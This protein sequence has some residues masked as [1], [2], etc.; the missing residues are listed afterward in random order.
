[1]SDRL[2]VSTVLL[3]KNCA[4]TLSAYF[5]SMQEV[6]DIILMDGGST[7]GTI[8][9][10]KAQSNC[11][12]FPQNP[13]FIDEQ[14]YI[15]DFSSIRN[16][17]YDLARHKW[18]LCIDADETA[19]AKLLAEVR[20]IV[21]TGKSGV[22]FAHRIF[23]YKGKPV[24]YLKKSASDQIRLF[25]LDSVRGCVKPVHEK[26]DVLPGSYRGMLDIELHIP[27]P[28]VEG[29]RRR[30]DRYLNIEVR[31]NKDIQLLRWFRWIFL[32]NL[33]A[34]PR[35]ILVS[36]LTRLIPKRGPRYP[37]ALEWEHWRYSWLLIWRTCPLFRRS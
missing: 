33:I 21:E 28:P 32:R 30:Y 18:I 3:T 24:V 22:Y 25:H 7:D 14:G 9:L 11:R 15:T 34:I 26:L 29:V 35:R 37:Y 6:D 17:G 16:E 36:V 19:S 10:A 31:H 5:A 13:R 12:I 8:E 23:Y 1:M 2:L 4:G 27:L 20:H